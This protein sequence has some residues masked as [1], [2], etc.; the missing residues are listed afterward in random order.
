[1]FKRTNINNFFDV[2]IYYIIFDWIYKKALPNFKLLMNN[3]AEYKMFVIVLKFLQQY[4]IDTDLLAITTDNA[5]FNDTLRKHFHNKM[6][7]HFHYI[8]NN[9]KNTINY[10]THVI[11]LV[12]N[13][14]LK[15][16]KK[17]LWRIYQWK[18]EAKSISNKICF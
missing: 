7:E 11:Q 13:C 8:W 4:F 2:I 10:M 18:N 9:E 17:N 6:K 3:H 16:L 14:I 1:M 15:T 5:K 12:F